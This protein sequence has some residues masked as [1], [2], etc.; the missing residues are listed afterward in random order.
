MKDTKAVPYHTFAEVLSM[1]GEHSYSA[2]LYIITE[3]SNP[4]QVIPYPFRSDNFI[5]AMQLEGQTHYRLNFVEHYLH[6]GQIQIFS[7]SAIRQFTNIEP[8]NSV[9]GMAFTSKFLTQS[10][11]NSKHIDMLDFF[12]STYP[13]DLEPQDFESLLNIQCLL[14]KKCAGGVGT[15]FDQEVVHHLFLSFLYELGAIYTRYNSDKKIQLTRKEELTMR[16]TK[17]LGESFKEERSV[18]FYADQLNVTP[19]YL[20]QT[21]KEITGKPPGSLID[22]MVVLEAKALLNNM[23]L[24]IAQ[25]AD[26]LYFSDQ[27]F[28]SKFFKRHTG[29]TPSEFR[30]LS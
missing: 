15:S 18:Q 16:F 28:F 14:Q 13:I 4:G 11:F 17:L 12:S 24:T 5:I 19:R 30:R 22:E 10:G 8:G 3:D 27:F 6:K 1:T 7:P 29:A 21:V 25:V 2:G 23:S 20:G 9:A 26:T